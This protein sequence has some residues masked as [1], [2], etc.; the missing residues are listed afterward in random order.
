MTNLATPD[1]RGVRL[2]L[3]RAQTHVNTLKREVLRM[4]FPNADSVPGKDGWMVSRYMGKI[5][6]PRFAVMV[7]DVAHNA[8]SALDHLAWQLAIANGT[9]PDRHNVFPIYTMRSQWMTDVECRDPS[10]GLSPLDG[11]SSAARQ[12]IR[13]CQPF[14][15]TATQKE[16]ARTALFQLHRISLIDKHRTLHATNMCMTE[17][18]PKLTYYTGP[19]AKFELVWLV[20]S[21]YEVFPGQE[22]FKWRV[23]VPVGD[24]QI[25]M[26]SEITTPITVGFDL[27]KDSG[28]LIRVRRLREIVSEVTGIVENL[29]ATV[30]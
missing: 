2:K 7:G 20:G 1:Y 29:I 16:A 24:Q 9:K 21:D 11:L 8:R 12:A 4:K 6:P 25:P 18:L 5:P 14:T 22:I 15:T 3:R 27:G 23:L 26:R 10:R 17:E 28:G 30:G 19:D 13:D